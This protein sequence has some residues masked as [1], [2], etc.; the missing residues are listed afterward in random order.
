MVKITDDNVIE[1]CYSMICR[2]EAA[3][4]DVGDL[5][6]YQIEENFNNWHNIVYDFMTEL[7]EYRNSKMEQKISK[8][9]PHKEFY[10]TDCPNNLTCMK[11]N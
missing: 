7:K 6:I 5:K 1:E 8:N 3:L 2:L 10:C 9:C 4:E 11:R